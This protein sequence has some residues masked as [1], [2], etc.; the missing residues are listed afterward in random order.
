MLHSVEVARTL[1]KS[2]ELARTLVNSRELLIGEKLEN[3]QRKPMNYGTLSNSRE[4]ARPFHSKFARN[5]N[6]SEERKRR[7]FEKND[8]KVTK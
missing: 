1:V 8:A 3:D 4:V 6:E 2:G 7:A 5:R